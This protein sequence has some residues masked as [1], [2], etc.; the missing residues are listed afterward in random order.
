MVERPKLVLG[1]PAE[2]YASAVAVKA[3]EAAYLA[4]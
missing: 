3:F 2:T 1:L 4:V